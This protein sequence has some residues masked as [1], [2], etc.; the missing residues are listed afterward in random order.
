V[1]FAVV[2]PSVRETVGTSNHNLQSLSMLPSAPHHPI[3]WGLGQSYPPFPVLNPLSHAV[4]TP[5]ILG[6]SFS[7]SSPLAFQATVQQPVHSGRVH[8]H[9]RTKDIVSPLTVSSS[10]PN[11]SHPHQLGAQVSY[12][13][14]FTTAPPP[15]THSMRE[16]PAGPKKLTKAQ[17]KALEAWREEARELSRVKFDAVFEALTDNPNVSFREAGKSL[18]IHYDLVRRIANGTAKLDGSKSGAPV[19]LDFSTE[20]LVMTKIAE[21]S[22]TEA[23]QGSTFTDVARKAWISL[24][25]V[26]RPPPL[27]TKSWRRGAMARHSDLKFVCG[28]R[29]AMELRHRDA[30]TRS[31]VNEAMMSLKKQVEMLSARFP[32]AP[33]GYIPAEC[34]GV[35]DETQTSGVRDDSAGNRGFSANGGAGVHVQG[36]L[37]PHITSMPVISLDGNLLWNTFVSASSPARLKNV[38]PKFL[39]SSLVCNT[40][41]SCE[42]NSLDGEMGSFHFFAADVVK[43]LET[44]YGKYNEDA[45]KSERSLFILLLDGFVV[46]KDSQVIGFLKENGVEVLMLAPNITHIVQIGDRGCINGRF[47]QQVRAQRANANS[48]FNGRAQ[49]LAEELQETEK[50]LIATCT[51]KN[52]REA[53]MDCGFLYT[54]C[55]MFVTMTDASVSAMLDRRESAGMLF[56]DSTDAPDIGHLRTSRYISA[57]KLVSEGVLSDG[58]AMLL[59]E[60]TINATQAAARPKRAPASDA[61]RERG[62]RDDVTFIRGKPGTVRLTCERVLGTSN[63]RLE[64]KRAAATEKNEKRAKRASFKAERENRWTLLI[65][66]FPD[67]CIETFGPNV[68]LYLD[69]KS[70][71]KDFAWAKGVVTKKLALADSSMT[72]PLA[73]AVASEATQ[74]KP[75]M[76]KRGRR[77]ALS[78]VVENPVK[79][80][81]LRGRAPKR[82]KVTKPV[83][84]DVSNPAS[85]V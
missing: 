8:A 79:V 69:N 18:G 13:P 41:G 34:L 53:A 46:H 17:A 6:Q 71:K 55:G 78:N 20:R 3:G 45:A 57:R 48:F 52:V 25:G 43:R 19:L 77:A 81:P 7:P 59:T 42:G 28:R 80:P 21:L 10:W 15:E 37:S 61:I 74:E 35:F 31:G 66:A 85:E 12:L 73:A 60:K 16:M 67:I 9:G 32:N 14:I 22:K 11:A 72:E 50:A 56:A 26:A 39:C 58:G 64:K 40:N 83:V 2:S 75:A 63:A 54:S 36:A 5:C 76:K 38:L 23:V 27:F 82:V 62:R 70:D 47:K 65:A 68:K 4:T 33:R 24:H 84:A 49:T 30:S 51:A 1:I 29:K 44:L